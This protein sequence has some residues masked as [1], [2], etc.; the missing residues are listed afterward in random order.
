MKDMMEML[1]KKKKS[2][3]LEPNYKKAKMGVLKDISDMA[4]SDMG[5]GIKGLKKVT[6][7]SPDEEGLK[8]GLDLAGDIVDEDANKSDKMD[9]EPRKDYSEADDEIDNEKA[10]ADEIKE[11]E[12]DDAEIDDLIKVLQ[13]KKK[14]SY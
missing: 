2:E 8:K 10:L 1:K 14:S 5:E 9:G 12:F 4:S 11:C 13:A 7:A 6:V 3:P